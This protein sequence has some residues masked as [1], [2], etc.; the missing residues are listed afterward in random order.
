MT[1]QDILDSLDV[2]GDGEVSPS[3]VDFCFSEGGNI[4]DY[5]IVRQPDG[6]IT[7]FIE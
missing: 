3:N 4:D 2:I 6:R 7:V 1:L 5:D